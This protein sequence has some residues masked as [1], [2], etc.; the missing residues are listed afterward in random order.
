[1]W[2]RSNWATDS[3][4][5]VGMQNRF[6]LEGKTFGIWEAFTRGHWRGT[7]HIDRENP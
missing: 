3:L 2:L 4:G 7:G 5:V 1:M 6:M